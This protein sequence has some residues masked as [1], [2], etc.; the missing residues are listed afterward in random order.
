MPELPEVE[1]AR[2]VIERSALHRRI[3][4]VDDADGYVCRPHRRGEIREA[5]V[6]RRLTSAH[7]RGKLMWCET[8][9]VG[10]SRTPGPVLALHLGMAGR[11][12]VDGPTG[13]DEGGDYVGTRTRSS[14]RHKP[15]WDRFT[16]RFEDGGSLRL[17]DKRRLG[18]VYLEPD[19]DRLGPDAG[20]VG[21]RELREILSRSR[22]PLKARLLD[23]HALA[24]VGN[25]LADEV[26]WQAELDP[27]RPADEI[28][29]DR[30]T[31]LHRSLR[32]AIRRALKRGGV[33][34]GEVIPYRKR[35]ADC[36]RC[37]AP[38]R[39]GVVGG[40]TT[41]WCSKEQ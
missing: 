28:E 8:S 24:G 9:G 2:A 10:R 16:L 11:I 41:W 12:L 6:G 33:H 32:T 25:L 21:L 17:F 20:E 38:M 40:R 4:D 31:V 30:V 22:A 5:L 23:Q 34:T 29:P 18:R 14:A 39:R 19:L 27:H 35:G 15:E 1:S 37:G 13:S 7:R 26:L 3:E 36:P